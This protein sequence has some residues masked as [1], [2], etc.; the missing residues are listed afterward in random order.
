MEDYK[1]IYL[2]V[3]SNITNIEN[4]ISKNE[5]FKENEKTSLKFCR[6]FV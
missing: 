5:N 3:N 1:K 4:I 6:K 2:E